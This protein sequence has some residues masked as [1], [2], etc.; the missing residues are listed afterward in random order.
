[1]TL[2]QARLFDSFFFLYMDSAL[3]LADAGNATPKVLC[4][5]AFYVLL[6][7]AGQ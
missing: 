6:G 3:F 1:M 2:I 4:P 5:Q 7:R